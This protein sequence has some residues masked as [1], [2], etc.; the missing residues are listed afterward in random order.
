[1]K[2]KPLIGFIGQGWIGKNYA[3][4]FENRGFPVVRYALEEP[5]VKNGKA[6]KDCGIVFVAVPT[7]S[8]PEGFDDSILRQAIKSAG[9]GA[10]VVIKSTVLPGTTEAIQSEHRDK[11]IMHSPEFLREASAAW[12]AAN[13]QRN[14]LGLPKETEEYRQAAAEVLAVLPKAP[15]ELVCGARSAELI[16]YV[17]NVFLHHKVI[18]FNMVHDLAQKLD[19]DYRLV[20]DAVAAD[21]RIQGSHMQVNHQ[22]GRGSGGHCFIKDKS[23]FVEM[24][25]KLVGDSEGLEALLALEKKNI[26][27]LQ[28]SGKDLDL[29]RGVYGEEA[30]K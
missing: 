15:F 5:Y 18:F 2:D 20:A 25:R 6:I 9:A 30:F 4:D 29:L 24:Y 28:E 7:P 8:T 3:D 23:A 12:D 22:G 1:M 21:P 19:C 13:P 27:Y 10:T 14:I 16:K 17:G 26:K 11:R